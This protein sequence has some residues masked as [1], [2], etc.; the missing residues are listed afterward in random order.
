MATDVLERI[1]NHFYCGFSIT[2]QAKVSERHSLYG[3]VPGA[4]PA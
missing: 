3:G 2:T 4:L 1:C